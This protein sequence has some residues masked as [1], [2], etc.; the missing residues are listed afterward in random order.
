MC[1]VTTQTCIMT[2][3]VPR[4]GYNLVLAQN[5]MYARQHDIDDIINRLYRHVCFMDSLCGFIA[6]SDWVK[7]FT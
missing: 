1:G 6:F 3:L 4:V 2:C 7:S 5:V